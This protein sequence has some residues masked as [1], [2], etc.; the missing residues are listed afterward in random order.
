MDGVLVVLTTLIIDSAKS[1]LVTESFVRR[2]DVPEKFFVKGEAYHLC[3]VK[4]NTPDFNFL[5]LQVRH[6]HKCMR[7]FGM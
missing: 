1:V 6:Q 7:G 3:H 5:T 2:V 4:T